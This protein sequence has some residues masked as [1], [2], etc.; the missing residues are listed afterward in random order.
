MLP[1]KD[2][3]DMT[4]AIGAV[5]MA[6]A[7]SVSFDSGVNDSGYCGAAKVTPPATVEI[8]PVLVVPSTSWSSGVTPSASRNP[9]WLP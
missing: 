2:R 9:R 3:L 7:L 6:S 1:P 4:G 5:G 8:W